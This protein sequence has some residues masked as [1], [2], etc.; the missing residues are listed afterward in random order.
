M[1]FVGIRLDQKQIRRIVE[2]L[3]LDGAVN[4]QTFGRVE[5]GEPKWKSRFTLSLE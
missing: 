3:L 2:H 1:Q 5:F 4:P